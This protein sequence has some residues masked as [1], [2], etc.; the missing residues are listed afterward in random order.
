MAKSALITGAG[1]GI[2]RAI[3]EALSADGYDLIL[4]SRTA[5][6]LQATRDQIQ[7]RFPER[8]VE[9]ASV[10]IGDQRSVDSFLASREFSALD[11]LVNNAGVYLRGSLELSVDQL[12]ELIDVNLIAT[13][14]FCQAVVP[15]MKARRRGYIFNIGSVCSVTGFAGVGGYCASKFGLLGLSESLYN[16]LVPHG[17]RVTAICPSW[18]ATKMA[19][20]SPVPDEDKIQPA[21]IAQ[22]VRFCLALSHGAAMKELIVPCGADVSAP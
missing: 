17:V 14:R 11:V 16:E 10:D 18:V 3:A 4:L 22:A 8:T 12:R 2:G 21:D 5:S 9:I 13:F 20:Q 6:E 7:S 15:H 19:A 1:R